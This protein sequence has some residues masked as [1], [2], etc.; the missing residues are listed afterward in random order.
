[1]ATSKTLFWQ[2]I[3]ISL[4]RGREAWGQISALNRVLDSVTFFTFGPA[5]SLSSKSYFHLQTFV[6]EDPCT[7][8][9]LVRLL[10]VLLLNAQLQYKYCKC[11]RSDLVCKLSGFLF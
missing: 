6:N 8:A 7:D 4:P 3:G 11:K 10:Q 1:M 9:W 5:E 2:Q